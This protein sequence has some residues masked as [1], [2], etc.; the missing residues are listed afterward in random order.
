[1]YY[2]ASKKIIENKMKDDKENGSRPNNRPM[3]IGR[4]WDFITKCEKIM[5]QDLYN[6]KLIFII[7]PTKRVGLMTLPSAYHRPLNFFLLKKYKLTICSCCVI[8]WGNLLINFKTLINSSHW[9]EFPK[10]LE[11][12]YNSRAIQAPKGL[13]L[14]EH[15]SSPS[16][17]W[18]WL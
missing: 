18:I 10:S 17:A 4:K 1:M 5:V 7:W 2:V 6:L 15:S 14:C 11:T 8:I 13:M 12:K 9:L 3:Y 16:Y